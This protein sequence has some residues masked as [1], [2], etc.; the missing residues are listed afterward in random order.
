LR[1]WRRTTKGRC[2]CAMT[3]VIRFCENHG[4]CDARIAPHPSHMT[5]AMRRCRCRGGQSADA[6]RQWSDATKA[7]EGNSAREGEV[8]TTMHGH[9]KGQSRC[10]HFREECSLLL[11]IEGGSRAFKRKQDARLK[12]GEEAADGSGYR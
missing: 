2:K 7:M 10:A 4:R 9:R 1:K 5:S 8:A 6:E 12:G 3:S 11:P